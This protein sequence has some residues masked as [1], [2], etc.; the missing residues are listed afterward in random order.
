MFVIV[1]NN[2][3]ILGPMRWNRYR[4][5]NEIKEECEV[6]ASLPDRNDNFDAIVVSEEVKILPVQGTAVQGT[7]DP[8][9]N[10][11]IEYLHGPFWEFTDTAA[12]QSFTV[13]KY[14]IDAVKNFLKAETANER[15]IKQNKS[16]SVTVDGVSYDFPTDENTRLVLQQALTS[17]LESFNWKLNTDTWVI[18][19]STN[20]QNILTQIITHIQTCFDWEMD[21]IAEIDACVAHLELD[22]LEIKEPSV[23]DNMFNGMI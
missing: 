1:Y 11:R 2:S 21:K 15:W 22:A 18:L 23:S 8:V 3:V 9:F 5:E 10:P 20:V 6:T 17:G 7:Q 16:V 12:I 14:N 19:T 4:F 13:E